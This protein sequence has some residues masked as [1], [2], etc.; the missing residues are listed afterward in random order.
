MPE[1]PKIS[2]ITASFNSEK[3]IEDSIRSVINQSYDNIEYIVIDGASKDGTL[4]F[5]SRYRDKIDII[6]SEQDAGIYDAY[7]KGVSLASGDVIY[8]LNT[9]D[10]LY[11][12]NIVRRISDVFRQ[13]QDVS[14]VYGNVAVIDERTGFRHNTGRR[15]ELKDFERGMMSSHQS[16]FTKRKLFDKYGLFDRA[17]KICSD[18]DFITKCFKGDEQSTLYID[19]T[20]AVYR[21]GG[22]S[23]DPRYQ[24]LLDVELNCI[25][26][27]HFN[28]LLPRNEKHLEDN[29]G[30]YRIW[31]DMLLLQGKGI[32]SS[33]DKRQISKVAIFGTRK[34]GI[35]LLKDLKKEG[36]DVL[37]FLDNNVNMQGVEVE[38]IMV[39]SPDWLKDNSNCIDAVIVSIEKAY[40]EDVFIQLRELT[41]DR[42][43]LTSWKD[44]VI[45]SI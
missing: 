6:V 36:F 7:N 14:I 38:G 16:I 3:Y 42:L 35:C 43:Y 27:K 23:N 26:Y 31:L 44:L 1:Y 8:F 29:N 37:T 32:S 11:D 30:L 15:M 4:D 25:V 45:R 34:T 2:I 21:E 41:G 13:N 39:V 19:E 12:D 20:I 28:K 5:V 9:D 10:Y 24:K 33:L 22:I 18:F 17:F 40:D